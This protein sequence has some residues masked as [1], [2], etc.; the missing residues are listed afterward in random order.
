MK[1]L[2]LGHNGNLGS[3]LTMR[4]SPDVLTSREVYCNGVDYDYVINCI[5][6]A[7]FDYCEEHKEESDYSNRDVVLDIQKWYPTSKI[8]NF[9]SYFVYDSVGLCTEDSPVTH[10]YNYTRQNLEK[11]QLVKNGVSFRLGK[12]FGHPQL[13]KQS[14][15][16]E[17]IIQNDDLFLDDVTFNPVSL[18]Q[19]YKVILYEIRMRDLH[20]IYNLANNNL[21]T[22]FEYGAF[23]NRMM[24]TSKKIT[25]VNEIKRTFHNNGRFTMSLDKLRKLVHLTDWQ[26]DM[27]TYLKSL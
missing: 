5:G 21:T 23:I 12:P 11:E 15:L 26:D 3:F 9:S 20:G 16:T 25:R 19:I 27:I 8:I 22:P 2:L 14:K 6:R 18:A 7:D 17:Y 24:G 4:L 13:S 1:I 10:K